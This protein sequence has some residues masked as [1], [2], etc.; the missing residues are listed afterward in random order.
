MLP[1]NDL[2]FNPQ[3]YLG[4]DGSQN[5]PASFQQLP[6][7]QSTQGYCPQT[8]SIQDLWSTNGGHDSQTTIP[9]LSHQARSER[10]RSYDQFSSQDCGSESSNLQKYLN[11]FI[12]LPFFEEDRTKLPLDEIK[13]QAHKNSDWQFPPEQFGFLEIN[14][15]ACFNSLKEGETD[16]LIEELG[17]GVFDQRAEEANFILSEEVRYGILKQNGKQVVLVVYKSIDVYT[18]NFWCSNI[19]KRM[20][21][22]CMCINGNLQAFEKL[23]LPIPSLKT[24]QNLFLNFRNNWFSLN[25][26]Y[27]LN[28]INPLDLKVF[29]TTVRQ[30]FQIE[31]YSDWL[32]MMM[33]DAQIIKDKATPLERRLDELEIL[34][35]DFIDF[36]NYNA[37]N[38]AE[39]DNIQNL[40]DSFGQHEEYFREQLVW[41]RIFQLENPT[42]K[43]IR[44]AH[45][46]TFPGNF[47][48]R[49]VVKI[50]QGFAYIDPKERKQL[51]RELSIVERALANILPNM[52]PEMRISE[53][54]N[55]KYIK[56]MIGLAKEKLKK[57]PL[58]S[59]HP[60]EIPVENI[61][62]SIRAYYE[63]R[64]AKIAP[65]SQQ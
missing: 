18:P 53:A 46:T 62:E 51:I 57:I 41:G 8:R 12:P 30:F 47:L 20:L 7:S 11:A 26:E 64:T 36:N 25:Q 10:K 65:A 32:K 40:L 34:R 49:G 6:Q 39:I 63:M 48:I 9:S 43:E 21:L 55:I 28:H 45:K 61:L 33:D 22:Q 42:L 16:F 37:Q 59:K 56:Y 29:E 31:N 38:I 19:V 5:S 52:L 14:V 44:L 2:T 17:D 3:H 1:P 24:R 27:L 58:N 50:V 4:F 23:K 54:D 13:L 15:Q 35:Q 60:E